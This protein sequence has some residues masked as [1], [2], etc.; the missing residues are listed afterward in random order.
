MMN[1][2]LPPPLERISGIETVTCKSST[3]KLEVM[4]ED[5]DSGLLKLKKGFLNQAKMKDTRP[6]PSVSDNQAAKQRGVILLEECS[7]NPVISEM[8]RIIREHYESDPFLKSTMSE[9]G[10]A[11]CSPEQDIMRI[12]ECLR[13]DPTKSQA[14]FASSADVARSFKQLMAKLGDHFERLAVA[15]Q[16]T[17]SGV[18]VPDDP[19]VKEILNDPKVRYLIQAIS[20]G[21]RVDPRAINRRDPELGRKIYY[22]IQTGY[23]RVN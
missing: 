10:I 17:Q 22:L 5:K 11:S 19:R 4:K 9:G 6:A 8:E 12:L 20:S 1:E 16:S 13:N 21:S 15:Q 2:D 3:E 23:L 14:M 7:K 18:Q